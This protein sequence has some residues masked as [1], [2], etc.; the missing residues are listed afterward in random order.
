MIEFKGDLTGNARKFLLKEQRKLNL[1]F[2]W[3]VS[4]LL[5][6]G[7]IVVSILLSLWFLTGFLFIAGFF[8]YTYCFTPSKNELKIFMPKR[9]Y[10]DLT[11]NSIVHEC[12]KME[13]FHML[14]SVEKVIDYGDWYYFIF[15][16]EDRDPYFVCQ[17]N[18]LT[19]GTIEE[20]EALFEGKIIR[21][22]AQE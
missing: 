3:I 6:I 7:L 5:G 17:K 19:Q 18:L 20:F 11:E 10:I 4:I 12:E 2:I 15:S 16:F 13:R 21:H 22:N 8:L 14:D 1:L 9:V